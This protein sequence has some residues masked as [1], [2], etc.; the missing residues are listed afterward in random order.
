MESAGKELTSCLSA[1]VAFFHAVLI[2]CVLSRMAP[3]EP[4]K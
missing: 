4:R 3:G 1:C 2:V